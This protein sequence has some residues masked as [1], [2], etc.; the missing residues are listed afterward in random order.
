M[1]LIPRLAIPLAAAML[2]ALPAPAPAQSFSPDQRHEIENI[3]KDYLMAHPQL[4]QD[5]INELDKQQKEAAAE[6]ARTT[7]KTNNATLFNS[8]H[9]VVLGNPHGNVT[10]VE[11]FDY[12]CGYCKHA[13]PDMMKL[14]QTDTNLKFVLKEFPV[15]GE[16]SVE[17]AHVA[18]AAR[19]QDPTGVKY[20]EFHQKL[21]GG[22]GAA[23]KMRAL[24]VAKEVGFDMGR[25][26]KDMDSD[27][28]KT[29]IAEDMKL[30][31][32]LGIDG[33]PSYVVGDELVVGAVGYDELQ[34]KI[35][36][37]RK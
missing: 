36:A 27:E 9:E 1:K 26:M 6:K 21:L 15:L 32:T 4:L 13:L 25:L 11:F 10:M 28:V 8:P 18:V 3:V 23:D 16:G 19:M 30:A 31:D 37:S 34:K 12:N 20:I 14:L 33:T 17:A 24:A 35:A 5:I 22:R 7:I 29:T 2:I